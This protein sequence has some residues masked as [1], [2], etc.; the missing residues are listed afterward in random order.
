MT[1]KL[2]LWVKG[3]LAIEHT[4]R[5]G[6]VAYESLGTVETLRYQIL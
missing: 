4:L 1:E 3:L 6:I 2:H 5:S